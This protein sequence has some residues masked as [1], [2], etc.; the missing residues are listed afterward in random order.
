MP[1]GRDTARILPGGAKRSR[2]PFA[3]PIL[4]HQ[5]LSFDIAKLWQTLAEGF[6][7]R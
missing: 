6:G 4:D 2:R 7:D 3:I 5:V 1:Q